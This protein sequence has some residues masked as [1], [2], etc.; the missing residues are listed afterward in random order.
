MGWAGGTS[1]GI[2]H[3]ALHSKAARAP[4]TRRV[5]AAPQQDHGARLEPCQ[6]ALEKELATPQ[7]LHVSERNGLCVLDS[8]VD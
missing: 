8:P 4:T 5:R 1:A 6:C 7:E 3:D 2:P